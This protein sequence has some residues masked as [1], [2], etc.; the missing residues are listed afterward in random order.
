MIVSFYAVLDLIN[1]S[2]LLPNYSF[3]TSWQW[4]EMDTNSPSDI[5]TYPEKV[6][7]LMLNTILQI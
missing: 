3:K 2:L 5:L 4:L 7:N 1:V 6:H